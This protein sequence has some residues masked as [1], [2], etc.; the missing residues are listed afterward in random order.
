MRNVKYEE[1]LPHEV[2]ERRTKHAVAYLPLGGLEWHGEHL[3]LGNDAL[4]AEKLCQLAAHK[5]GGIA[6]PVL[7]YGEPRDVN[8]METYHD[9]DGKIR[10]KMKLP[11]SSF[12]QGALGTTGEEQMT[13]YKK[14]ITH[15]LMQLRSLGFKAIVIVTGHYPIEEW[16]APTIDEFNERNADC[17][18]YAGIEYRF[19]PG[20]K[21]S[22]KVGG[23]HAAMWETSYLMY[24]RP[25]CVDMTVFRGRDPEEKLIGVL[26]DDPRT[27]ASKELGRKACRL[28]VDGMV[29]K[30]NELLK[31]VKRRR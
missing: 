26:G 1:M 9:K 13:M 12:K 2:V 29:S 5:G 19:G 23:D 31:K 27:T 10:R 21:P 24:L 3:A 18:A 22:A 8:I 30:G 25:E 28:I 16:I 4:K 17:Q 20:G 14:L 15:T 7:W 6:C 11:A